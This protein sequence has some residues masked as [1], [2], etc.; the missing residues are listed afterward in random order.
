MITISTFF[1]NHNIQH[2]NNKLC[3]TADAVKKQLLLLMLV[4]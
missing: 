1:I 2:D 3:F 4:L